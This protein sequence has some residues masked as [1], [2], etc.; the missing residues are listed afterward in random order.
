MQKPCVFD[1]DNMTSIQTQGIV[2]FMRVPGPKDLLTAY[3]AM[4]ETATALVRHLGGQLLDQSHSILT[5]QAIEQDKLL[6]RDYA[7]KQL[8]SARRG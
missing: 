5:K 2:F 7:R 6:L 1:I 8:L 3:E 4:L